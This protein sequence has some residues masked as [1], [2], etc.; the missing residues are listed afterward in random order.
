M[1][2]PAHSRRNGPA[3]GPELRLWGG[4][5]GVRVTS[6]GLTPAQLVVERSTHS[7]GAGL[8]TVGG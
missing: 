7:D 6:L 2:I 1:A 8:L 4:R 5:F 3:V